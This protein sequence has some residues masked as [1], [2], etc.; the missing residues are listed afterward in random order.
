LLYTLRQGPF[1]TRILEDC[2][3][4]NRPLPRSIQEAPELLPGLSLY[5]G[6][7]IELQ[8]CRKDG[9]STGRVPWTEV[10]RYAV[11]SEFS[12]E[13]IEDLHHYVREMD[14]AYLDWAEEERKRRGKHGHQQPG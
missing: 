3:R 2:Y 1:E 6:A 10:Q 11:W 8:S 7:Y 4:N 12:A 13:Q 5:Y 9:F 14:A